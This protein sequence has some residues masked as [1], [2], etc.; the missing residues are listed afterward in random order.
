MSLYK[1]ALV[2]STLVLV[3][4]VILACGG[5]SLSLSST[6]QTITLA[7]ASTGQTES[8]YTWTSSGCTDS[9][10]DGPT[11][12]APQSGEIGVGYEVVTE[13][14]FFCDLGRAFAYF[15][16]PAFAF[17]L[18]SLLPPKTP[19]IV[20]QSA[21]L[22]YR[23]HRS[24]VGVQAGQSF[25]TTAPASHSCATGLLTPT[26]DPKTYTGT[27]LLPGDSIADLTQE[28]TQN[29]QQL[30]VDVTPTVEK[31]IAAP[32]QNFG[33]EFR[34]ELELQ[35]TDQHTADTFFMTEHEFTRCYSYYT[36]VNLVVT[37]FAGH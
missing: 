27:G 9:T 33:L 29:D 22:K 2:S 18:S 16:R 23:M 13:N 36:D 10:L 34:G 3:S 21:T 26:I 17:D 35:G 19:S 28:D 30:Q 11:K 12:F 37:Y 1:T 24:D 8:H 31:W 15:F 4:M 14:S 5:S 20:I 6:P 7:P 25:A 32:D